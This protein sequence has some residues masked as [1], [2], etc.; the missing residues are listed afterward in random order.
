MRFPVIAKPNAEGTSKGLGP[1]SVVDDLPGLRTLVAKLIERYRQP[2][3]VEEY[4][5]GREL[6][7]GLLGLGDSP[8]MLPPMEVVFKGGP[9][10]PVYGYLYKQDFHDDVAYECP[11]KLTDEETA[12]VRKVCSAAFAALGCR[13]VARVDIR[14]DAEGKAHVLEVNPLPGLTPAFSD[15]CLISEAAGLTY[16]DLVAAI[17][18]RARSEAEMRRLGSI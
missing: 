2:V 6:T 15:L 4:V 16:A 3:I 11:A 5:S 13:D 18:A 9:A 12:D 1:E 8:R 17:L 14:L 7:V 10:R